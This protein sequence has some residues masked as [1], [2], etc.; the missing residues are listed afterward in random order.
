MGLTFLKEFTKEENDKVVAL[1][2]EDGTLKQS[3]DG[4]AKNE[5]VEAA[6]AEAKTLYHADD[7]NKLKTADFFTDQFIPIKF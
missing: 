2:Y 7:L 6:L 4:A 3:R 1:S 5:W